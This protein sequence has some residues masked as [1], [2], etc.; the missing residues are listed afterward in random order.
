MKRISQGNI[1][2]PEIVNPPDDYD[3]DKYRALMD[4]IFYCAEPQED[5]PLS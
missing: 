5:E 2:P 4:F 3:R 1:P